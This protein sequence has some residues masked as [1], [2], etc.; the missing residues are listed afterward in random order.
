MD[1][2]L[3]INPGNGV[4]DIAFGMTSDEVEKHM[5]VAEEV[6]NFM[7]VSSDDCSK[8]KETR[9]KV[10]YIYENDKLICISGE[11]SAPFTLDGE[12]LPFTAIEVI[13]FL[14]SKSKYNIRL[15]DIFSYI[16]ADIGIVL[17][18]YKTIDIEAG[19]Q[20]TATTQ[21]IAICDNKVL[22]RYYQHF[23]HKQETKNDELNSQLIEQ[24]GRFI[25]DRL[26]Q[27]KTDEE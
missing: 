11:L 21:R 4:N 8:R 24:V 25:E 14:K 5:G 18:P 1:F 13:K 10:S 2:E 19:V 27:E 9:G 7:S 16:F 26:E 20:S 17:Y 3:K 15:V 6:M 23:S 22:Q 12:K